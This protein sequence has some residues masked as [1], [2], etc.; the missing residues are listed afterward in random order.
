MK[1]HTLIVICIITIG[2]LVTQMGQVAWGELGGDIGPEEIQAVLESGQAAGVLAA[3]REPD[4]PRPKQS[5]EQWDAGEMP[6]SEAR[7]TP[8]VIENGTSEEPEMV[9]NV[10]PPD[11]EGVFSSL[12]YEGDI[13]NFLKLLGAAAHRNIVPSPSVSGSVSVNLFGVTFE[14]ILEA[15]LGVN[16]YVYE[17]EGPFI[18]V[19]SSAEKK[20]R[21]QAARETE[22]RVFRLNYVQASDIEKLITPLLSDV[23]SVTTNPGAGGEG[24]E[25]WVGGNCLVL[26]DYSDVIEKVS[27]LLEELDSRPP[28]VLVE[29]TILAARLDDRNELGIDFR[30]L[31]GVNFQ[32]TGGDISVPATTAAVSGTTTT[33]DTGFTANVSDGG[34]SVGIIQNNIGVFIKAVE[35]ITDTVTLGN[36]KVLTLNRQ[37]GQVR[38]GGEQGYVTSETTATAT[39]QTVENLETGTI[40][41]FRPFVMDDGYIRMELHPEDSTGEVVVK[42]GFALPEKTTAE[43]TTNVLV[44]DGDTIVIGGLFRDSTSTGRSQI[45]LLGNLPLLGTLFRST[46]DTVEK[47][48]LIFLITPHIVEHNEYSAA[49]REVLDAYE[50]KALSVREGLQWHGRQQLAEAHYRRAQDHQ[51][52]GDDD[53]ALWDATM[54]C[55]ISPAYSDAARLRDALRGWRRTTGEYGSMRLFM[56]QLVEQ[57]N[58]IMPL[59]AAPVMTV[60]PVATAAAVPAVAPVVDDVVV[61]VVDDVAS[62]PAV[63]AEMADADVN[64]DV[65]DGVGE[66]VADGIDVDAVWGIDD[67]AD[68][69]WMATSDL[70][71][72]WLESEEIGT[73]ALEPTVQPQ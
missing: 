7:E 65:I 24:G 54:A 42:G 10:I 38:V 5:D 52:A 14:E 13:V 67:V 39:T 72:A 4:E 27:E 16:D 61:P 35:S 49:S 6:G 32:T 1:Q 58:G 51:A 47:E 41:T 68:G 26:K 19:Y 66:E 56:R 18:F 48:E 20:D 30:V 2:G 44:R 31:G 57:D 11:A 37:E 25:S 73:T 23:A 9:A 53:M 71:G 17:Q 29:A 43:V 70:G 60:T 46:I 12:T 28:Q 21:M 3:T 45:P 8:I 36:P 59:S 15:V 22:T 33:A 55:H 69:D 50:Q 62:A 34:L 64:V 40:L 63:S